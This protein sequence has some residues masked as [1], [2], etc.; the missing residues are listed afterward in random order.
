MESLSQ[1][2]GRTNRTVFLV[3]LLTWAGGFFLLFGSSYL[4]GWL[5]EL[6]IAAGVF[7]MVVGFP[8]WL[9]FAFKQIGAL[10]T[11]GLRGEQERAPRRPN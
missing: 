11:Y 4:Q 1:R 6:A 2:L 5:A 8:F 9:Y 3:C 10:L 7:L